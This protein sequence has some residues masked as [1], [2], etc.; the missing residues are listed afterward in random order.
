MPLTKANPYSIDE[1]LW[2]RSIETGVLEDPWVEPPEDVYQW[3]VSSANA[4][5][6]PEY[7]EIEFENGHS[8]SAGR[9]WT[10]AA[11]S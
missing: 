5:D 11:W 6:E 9:S 4:P 2:G 10:S 3:T 7:H 8:S 1:N